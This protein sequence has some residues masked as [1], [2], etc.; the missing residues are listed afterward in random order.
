TDFLFILFACAV[1]H[2]MLHLSLSF[3]LSSLLHTGL[4][5]GCLQS[6]L[7]FCPPP[8]DVCFF[9]LHLSLLRGGGHTANRAVL[10]ALCKAFRDISFSIL[11]SL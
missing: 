4:T 11:K 7:A 3:C 10:A 1:L 5:K 9:L 8:L 6:F 2:L